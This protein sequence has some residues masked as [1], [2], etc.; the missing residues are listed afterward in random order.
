MHSAKKDALKSAVRSKMKDGKGGSG[1]FSN[2]KNTVI[3]KVSNVMAAPA[4]AH[5]KRLGKKADRDINV[6]QNARSF[7]NSAMLRFE[8]G[9]PTNR[10]KF[11]TARD[12]VYKRYKQKPHK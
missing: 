6:L 4:V 9:V 5:Y 10:V 12:D 1:L 3:D 7:D 11:E 8:K 2:L